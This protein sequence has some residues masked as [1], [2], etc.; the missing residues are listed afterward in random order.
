MGTSPS[1]PQSSGELPQGG[2]NLQ[3][4][5]LQLDTQVAT[6]TVSKEDRDLETRKSELGETIDCLEPGHQLP[7]GDPDPAERRGALMYHEEPIVD[8]I[9]SVSRSL[10]N[11]ETKESPLVNDF[12]RQ[13][14]TD[15]MGGANGAAALVPLRMEKQLLE[16]IDAAP[17]NEVMLS[18]LPNLF[19]TT[20]RAPISYKQFGHSKL[21][22][23]LDAIPSISV[24]GQN[25]YMCRVEQ[26]NTPDSVEKE[27]PPTSTPSTGANS[28]HSQGGASSTP[29][30]LLGIEKRILDNQ[31]GLAAIQ[32]DSKHSEEDASSM[33]P[34]LRAAKKLVSTRMYSQMIATLNDNP[35]GATTS[36]L[37]KSAKGLVSFLGQFATADSAPFLSRKR[38]FQSCPGIRHEMVNGKIKFFLDITSFHAKN[39]DGSACAHL[40]PTIDAIAAIECLRLLDHAYLN[41]LLPTTRKQLKDFVYHEISE[42]TFIKWLYSSFESGQTIHQNR[43]KAIEIIIRQYELMMCIS[44]TFSK[45]LE[46]N[47]VI[48]DTI[49]LKYKSWTLQC[50]NDI[51][52]EETQEEEQPSDFDSGA[53]LQLIKTIEQLD[54][55]KNLA[56]FARSRND[57]AQEMVAIDC[58][59]APEKLFLVQV[60]TGSVTY[61]FDCVELGAKSVCEVLADMLKD[62]TVT[63]LFHDLHKDTFAFAAIGQIDCLRGTFDTQLAMECIT[64]DIQMGFNRMLKQLGQEPHPTKHS[65]KKRMEGGSLFA[66]RPMTPSEIDYAAGDVRLLIR[67]KEK[68]ATV[69]GDWDSWHSVQLASDK[70]AAMASRNGGARK[71]CFDTANK[72]ALASW[73]LLQEKSPDSMSIP[74]PLVVSDES[75]IL[76]KLLPDDLARDLAGMTESLSDIVLDLGR[77]PLAWVGQNRVMLGGNDRIVAPTDIDGIVET[78]GGF[79]EDNR[80]GLEKQLHRISAIRNRESEIIGLTMR[81]VLQKIVGLRCPTYLS[82]PSLPSDHRPCIVCSFTEWGV[83]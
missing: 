55:V 23:F 32:P 35:N 54:R 31:I 1:T 53:S 24:K 60:A 45:S 41:R 76:I 34:E 81:Y 50:S 68:L 30:W 28:K 83:M 14:E 3:P 64:G 20:F 12:E 11:S 19:K 78:L 47:L 79:G 65:M 48:V 61:I 33:P 70:R 18:K 9:V 58:E 7:R 8:A 6:T 82:S 56:P 72:Y 73:E 69:L 40:R 39:P 77:S 74:M 59:G 52:T 43:K 66:K 37:K 44:T 71:I 51:R 29:P 17:G 21:K 46:W 63:K 10:D 27:N 80:A 13:I 42:P 38:V 62:A 75:D 25:G 57:F 22:S 15:D 36:Q 2:C 49:L 4:M 26:T 16:L 67:C 5:Q